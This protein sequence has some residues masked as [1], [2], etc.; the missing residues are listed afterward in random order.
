VT[1]AERFDDASVFQHVTVMI[2]APNIGRVFEYSGSFSYGI[3]S[4][5][6]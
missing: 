6:S 1:L 2:D 4:G 3:R 5:K